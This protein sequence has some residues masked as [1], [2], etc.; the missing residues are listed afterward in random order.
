MT[1]DG[2]KVEHP[3]SVSLDMDGRWFIPDW[4]VVRNMTLF[5]TDVY[6]PGNMTCVSRWLLTHRATIKITDHPNFTCAS[7][8]KMYE[9]VYNNPALEAC[10]I[11]KDGEK[12][13]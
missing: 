4:R 12:C 1:L 13:L 11:C 3:G 5:S 7:Y 6:L 8:A 9:L 10:G 2:P